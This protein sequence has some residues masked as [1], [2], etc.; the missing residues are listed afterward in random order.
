MFLFTTSSPTPLPETLV[1]FFAVENPDAKIRER[2][3]L[4]GRAASEPMIPLSMAFFLMASL[5]IPFPSS[6]IWITT[7]APE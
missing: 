5:S 3:S 1:T 2:S 4:S 7:K 6:W